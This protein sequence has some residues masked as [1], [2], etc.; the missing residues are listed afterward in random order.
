MVED[1]H[2]LHAGG[3]YRGRPTRPSRRG[4]SNLLANE[5]GTKGLDFL[6]GADVAKA[7]AE[8]RRWSTTATTARPGSPALHDHAFRK[9]LYPD[10]DQLRAGRRPD[11]AL[12]QVT[13]DALSGSRPRARSDAP[14]LSRHL[15]RHQ[16]L[17]EEGLATEQYVS[18]STPLG[19]KC[20][21]CQGTPGGSL[22]LDWAWRRFAGISY[23][24]SRRCEARAGPQDVEGH[25]LSPI[26]KD[27]A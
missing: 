6:T 25:V 13:A 16:A 7:E 1:D 21:P 19:C 5:R 10:Q 27:P 14:K 9:G 26:H 17:P 23:N 4:A 24:R 15:A 2:V 3:P 11:A 18:P 8:G 20:A 22:H 12:C